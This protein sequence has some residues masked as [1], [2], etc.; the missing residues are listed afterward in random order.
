MATAYDPDL[1]PT[2]L[3]EAGDDD[4]DGD[5]TL[6]LSPI[7]KTST[8]RPI[9]PD[10]EEE[11]SFGGVDETR[12]LLIEEMEIEQDEAWAKIISRF[13]KVDTS[14]FTARLNEFKQVVVRL[15][16]KGSKPYVLF[17]VMMN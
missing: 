17:K 4:N 5:D 13:P 3:N 12:P 15:F 8:T 6:Y 7:T 2:T 9:D 11:T 14:K 1:D 10:E 16:K